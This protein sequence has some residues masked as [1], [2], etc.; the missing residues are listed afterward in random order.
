MLAI[1]AA[2]MLAAASQHDT[3]FT[4][5]GGRVVGTVVEE[6]PSGV[7]VQLP[8]GSF[9]RYAR[10]EIARIEY[11]DGTVTRL[12]EPPPPPAPPALPTYA[13]APVPAYV[14]PQP[15][16]A[17]QPQYAPPPYAP[18]PYAPPQ[19][20][21]PPPPRPVYY[22]PPA[23]V[24]PPPYVPP[25]APAPAYVAQKRE[26]GPISPFYLSFGLGGAALSGQAETGV[27]IDR[28]FESQVDVLFEGGLRLTPRLALALYADLGVGEP[29]GEIRD[30]CDA[31]LVDCIGTTGRVGL[32]LRHTFEPAAS[33]TPW[34]AIGTGYEFGSI[35]TDDDTPHHDSRELFAYSG[36]EML[37]LQA[38]VD[39]R[40]NRVLGIGFY[41]GVSLGRYMHYEDDLV[42]EDLGLE[43]LHTIV[44]GGVR[45]T[46]FP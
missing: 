9:R 40:S 38:G 2:V 15:P 42:A 32:M 30:Q 28:I 33:A 5:E 17:P 36:W 39:L 11:A 8:D 35:S 43:P 21:P 45:L 23:Y 34:L 29:A 1:L 4:A 41:G 26:T 22:P 24:P 10:R 6:G 46:L 37:R 19:Y 25:S 16:P 13:P 20:A 12:S 14:P 7:A 31:A 18:Q 3:V 27:D 44:E